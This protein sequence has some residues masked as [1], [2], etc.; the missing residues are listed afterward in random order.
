[1]SE[2]ALVPVTQ[3]D[4]VS[5]WFGAVSL[6]LSAGTIVVLGLTWW[7]AWKQGAIPEAWAI[8]HGLLTCSLPVVAFF[9]ALVAFVL[10]PRM[11]GLLALITSIGVTLVLLNLWLIH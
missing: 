5:G 10:R 6:G 2:P 11:S 4:R 3:R 7:R 1:M 8:F 9:A